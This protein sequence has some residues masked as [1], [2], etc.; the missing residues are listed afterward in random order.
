MRASQGMLLLNLNKYWCDRITDRS[1]YNNNTNIRQNKTLFQM[2]VRF[3]DAF[4]ASHRMNQRQRMQKYM[5]LFFT[6]VQIQLVAAVVSCGSCLSSRSQ[7]VL[8]WSSVFTLFRRASVTPPSPP[9]DFYLRSVFSH[10]PSLRELFLVTPQMQIASCTP[11]GPMLF[12][13]S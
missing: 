2:K 1:R 12:F 11:C 4:P 8:L 3:S 9:S 7:S 6:R 10:V 13:H 5:L